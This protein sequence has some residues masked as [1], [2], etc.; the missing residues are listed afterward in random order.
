MNWIRVFGL[1]VAALLILAAGT[2]LED[3]HRLK[4]RMALLGAEN[5]LLATA[6]MTL[7]NQ[8]TSLEQRHERLFGELAEEK[9]KL[10][11]LE[12]GSEETK[13]RHMA[14]A[15][16]TVN[17]LRAEQ[18]AHR[19]IR[20][21]GGPTDPMVYFEAAM[22]EVRHVRKLER[23]QEPPAIPLLSEAL[24]LKAYARGYRFSLLGDDILA[25]TRSTKK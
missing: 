9:R 8:F 5:Q 13:E 1:I 15:N 11:L 22:L 25:V 2:L 14:Y 16:A 19:L 17:L 18:L 12:L 6:K 7:Q 4:N 3:Y 24:L 21:H 20:D 23:S 10:A